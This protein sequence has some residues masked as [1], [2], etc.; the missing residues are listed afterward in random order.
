[1]KTRLILF[2]LLLAPASA[3]EAL[4]VGTSEPDFAFVRATAFKP[5]HARF[6]IPFDEKA[7][8]TAADLAARKVILLVRGATVADGA[9]LRSWVARGGT[10]L[11]FNAASPADAP[12][13]DLGP[14]PTEVPGDLRDFRLVKLA[15]RLSSLVEG[16]QPATMP[17]KREPWGYVPLG[18]PVKR[19]E[20]IEPLAAKR[21]LPLLRRERPVAGLALTLVE[22]GRARCV[23][24]L[25]AKPSAAL[26]AAADDFVDALGRIS[27]A[28]VP[29]VAEGFAVAAD[30]ARIVLGAEGELPP[31]IAAR[32]KALPP[33]GFL[34]IAGGRA[35]YLNGSDV[36]QGGMALTGTAH[37]VYDF[38]ERQLGVWWLWPGE[39]GTVF[40]RR[41]TVTVP[42][43]DLE[44][45][46]AVAVR[47][48]RNYG[49]VSGPADKPVIGLEE[50]VKVALNALGRPDLRVYAA[51]H[52]EA[53]PWFA[54]LRLGQS[55]RV[56]FGHAYN[57]YAERFT[58]EHPDW[59]AQQPDG[60][61]TPTKVRSR[62][63][64][65][66]PGLIAQAARDAL[67][68]LDGDPLLSMAALTPNDG[69]ASSWDL[70]ADARAAGAVSRHL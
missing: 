33:E 60:T 30:N 67:R 41:A 34:Q 52:A 53:N 62:R 49:G 51:K 1:M 11:A 4:L 54:R 31:E 28:R 32:V 61:R 22:A 55:Q 12:A 66:N 40:P 21:T 59:F 56:S 63:N 16:A 29:V 5:F 57:D 45:D 39:G 27:G 9:A 10:L 13:I 26:R 38:I 2:L 8:L 6:D 35:L 68:E 18:A 23:I 19:P 37:G 44:D 48:L 65:E 15:D 43:L 7:S 24:V 20:R 70:D 64:K 58:D 14:D 42:P 25:P 36:G 50:R 69:G 3:A 46:P 17:T 47:R